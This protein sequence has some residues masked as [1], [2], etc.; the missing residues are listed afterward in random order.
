MRSPKCGGRS[1]AG[2][3]G[4]MIWRDA[5]C[6][7]IRYFVEDIS[8]KLK[9]WVVQVKGGKVGNGDVRSVRGTI[10]GRAEM[11]L[12]FALLELTGPMRQTSAEAGFYRSSTVHRY[13]ASSR[14]SRARPS[15]T[16]SLGGVRSCRRFG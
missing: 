15:L 14:G 12:H 1:G 4:D 8:G 16:C 13:R 7:A 6:R 10:D 11:A 3:T 2:V 9:R 5:I